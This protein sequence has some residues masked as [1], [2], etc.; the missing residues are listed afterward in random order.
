MSSIADVGRVVAVEDTERAP[1]SRLLARSWIVRAAT[2]IVGSTLLGIIFALPELNMGMGW[3]QP[4][5][6]WWA[7][8]IVA[9]LIVMADRRFPFSGRQLGRRAAAHGVASL[10]FTALYIHVFFA[11]RVAVHDATLPGGPHWGQLKPATMLKYGTG[12]FA[13]SCLIY[14]M[15]VGTLQAY[16]Y[17]E[18]YMSSELQLERME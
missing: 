17:Y 14:W 12:W 4:L 1:L 6:Q 13:W 11:V 7:W 15:I 10:V 3:K 9:P 5:S 16:R 8:G 2:V 18:R